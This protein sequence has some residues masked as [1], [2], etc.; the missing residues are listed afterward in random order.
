[1]EELGDVIP[2]ATVDSLLYLSQRFDL[3]GRVGKTYPVMHSVLS[4]V[5]GPPTTLY[6]AN[7]AVVES[8]PVIPAMDVIAVSGG[9][10]SIGTAITIGFNCDGDA[11]DDPD[12]LAAG[13][14]IGMANLRRCV[15]ASKKPKKAKRVKKAKKA[16]GRASRV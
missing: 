5:P 14:D 2:P 12:L 9:F 11:V 10:V 3:L 4:N 16:K 7:G 15:K 13:V 8:I 1:M 6:I